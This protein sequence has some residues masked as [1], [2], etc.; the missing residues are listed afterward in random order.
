MHKTAVVLKSNYGTTEKYARW[1]AEDTKADLFESGQVKLEVLLSYDTIVYCGGLYAGGMLGFRFIKKNY[2]KLKQKRLIVVA[3]GATLKG[4]EAIA[5]IKEKNLIP[6]MHDVPFFLLRG[7]LNYP[8]MKLRHRIMMYLMV[9]KLK[10]IKPEDRNDDTKGVLAT[11][12]KAVDF[13]NRKAIA[14]VVEAALKP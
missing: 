3:V 1:I 7:G 13:T 5:E 2:E 6:E 11:Y 14:P 9:Q 10:G 8:K 4:E 12:G